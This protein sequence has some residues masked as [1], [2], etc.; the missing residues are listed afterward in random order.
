MSVSSNMLL[1]L[2]HRRP[3]TPVHRLTHSFVLPRGRLSLLPRSLGRCKLPQSPAPPPDGNKIQFSVCSVIIGA[4]PAVG[5]RESGLVLPMALATNPQRSRNNPTTAPQRSHGRHSSLSAAAAAAATA[6]PPLRPTLEG[7]AA[8]RGD[9]P[10]P[11]GHRTASPPPRVGRRL[12]T[13][14]PHPGTP[15]SVA[16]ARA[17]ALVAP[18]FP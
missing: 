13:H 14:C 5:G 17:D 3:S 8:Q 10:P 2:L 1:L 6:P 4:F 11:P 15:P 16:R 18:S 12:P 7:S 9:P